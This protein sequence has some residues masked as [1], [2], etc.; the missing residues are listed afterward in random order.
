MTALGNA[1]VAFSGGVDSTLVLAVAAEVLGDRCVAV[2]GLS[3]T[4]AS[5]E[6][7]DA[8][9]VAEGLGARY[10]V[11]DTM[12]LDD[13]RYANNSHQRCYFCKHE[14]Y[15]KL[16][17]WA[18]DHGFTHIVDGTNLDD[19]DDFRPGLRAA[20]ELG[21]ASPL[22]Q[23]GFTKDDVRRLSSHLGLPTANKPATACLSSRF[24]YG[25]PITVEKLRKVAAAEQGVR[26]LGFDGFR[27]RYHGDVARIEMPE[28]D[29]P[30]A[31]EHRQEVIDAVKLAGFAYVALDLEPFRSG[32]MNKT[33][34]LRLI[35]D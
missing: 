15:G 25:D 21:V 5:S 30:R 9:R 8:K 7:D 35:A 28:A 2:S 18:K 17:A 20:R 23:L 1:V 24:A 34:P 4:Y 27:V 26:A 31:F 33:L 10:V 19:G 29:L 11:V 14:L 12:E 6:M 22:K 32:S 3:A 13:P 16:G